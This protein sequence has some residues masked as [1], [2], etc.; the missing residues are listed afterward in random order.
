MDLR[1]NIGTEVL[2]SMI[3]HEMT[4]VC[5]ETAKSIYPDTGK[6]ACSAKSVHESTGMEEGSAKDYIRDF[7]LMRKG[8]KLGRCMAEM[9]A[10]FYFENIYKDFGSDALSKALDSLDAYLTSDKQN[11]PGLENLIEEFRETKLGGE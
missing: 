5:Y 3:T 2:R 11:H 7:F 8:E 10:R 9:G 1:K 6:I 4:K